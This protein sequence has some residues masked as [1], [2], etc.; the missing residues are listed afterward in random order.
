MIQATFESGEN[1]KNPVGRWDDDGYWL[2]F[3]LHRG[4]DGGDLR[5][6]GN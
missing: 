1:P 3:A 2:E 4:L 6:T 5:W